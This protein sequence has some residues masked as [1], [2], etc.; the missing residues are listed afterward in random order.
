MSQLFSLN[1][2]TALVT[3]GTRGIG[4]AMAIALAEAGAE[5]IL[6]QVCYASMKHKYLALRYEQNANLQC[7]QRDDSNTQTR[8]AIRALDRTCVIFPVSKPLDTILRSI[9]CPE[10]YLTWLQEHTRC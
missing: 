9:P 5:I 6:V 8:D 4:Q 1:G 3:G 2:Q 7:L 10:A